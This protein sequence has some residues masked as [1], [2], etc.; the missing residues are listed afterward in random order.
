MR[1]LIVQYGGDYREVFT[2][3]RD[4]GVET[5]H[6]QK[7]VVDAITNISSNIDEVILLCCTTK[8]SYNQVISKGLRVIGAGIEPYENTN[9]ILQIIADQKPTNLVVLFP[10][11]KIFSWAIKNR[12]RTMGLFSDSFLQKGFRRKIKNHMLAKSLN[13][14]QIDF[15]AN[16][17]I[18][19]CLSLH[20]IGVNYQKIIPCDFPHILTPREFSPKQLPKNLSLLYVGAIKKEKGVGNIIE[21]VAILEKRNINVTLKIAGAGDVDFFKHQAESLK[22]LNKIEFLG[23]VAHQQVIH[24]MRDASI[25]VVPS[26]HEYPEGLPFTIYEALCS[27]TPLVV[28]DHPMFQGNLQHRLNAMVFPAGDSN[29]L[30]KTIAQL[31]NEANLYTQISEASEQAW[32]HLQI[33]VKWAELIERWLYSSPNNITWLQSHT[34]ASGLYNS[35]MC[36]QLLKNDIS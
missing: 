31:S 20:Q 24:L 30:A 28:S 11:Q 36:S 21:A 26:W 34:L 4:N 2:R 29:S 18:N 15:V 3:V 12:I 8:H 14:P 16:H 35:R 32:E 27:R 19:A 6:A 17:G 23:L 9:H 25:V 1:L 5:Y 22:V 7:Y 33:P 10:I 13:H